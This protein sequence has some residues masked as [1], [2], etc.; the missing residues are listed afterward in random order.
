MFEWHSEVRDNEIDQ[1]GVVNNANYFIYMAHARHK[2]MK[3]LGIDF[4]DY[5]ARGLNLLLIHTEMSFKDSLKSGDEFIVTS[6]IVPQGRIRFAF[7]QQVIRKSDNKVVTIA[8]NTATCINTKTGRPEI[9]D[10]LKA[11]FE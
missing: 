1:Q 3:S 9:P 10:E 6:E 2:H 4:A 5:A 11:L 7:Q 8:T